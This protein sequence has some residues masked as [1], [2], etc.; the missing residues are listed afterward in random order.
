[1]K[2]I[3]LIALLAVVLVMQ[4][5]HAGH[6][7]VGRVKK[8]LRVA[9]YAVLTAAGYRS[10]SQ[11]HGRNPKSLWPLKVLGKMWSDKLDA[12]LEAV[13]GSALIWYG[14]EGIDKELHIFHQFKR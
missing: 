1:M 5:V 11:F 6:G 12:G 3:K 2:S 10:L 7:E 8:I 9:G 4:P 14:L 13:G